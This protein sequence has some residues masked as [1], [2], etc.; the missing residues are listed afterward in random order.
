[1]RSAW[2]YSGPLTV[3]GAAIATCGGRLVLAAGA[4]PP[5]PLTHS[6]LPGIENRNLWG[7]GFGSSPMRMRRAR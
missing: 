4:T 2:R 1:M 7:R 5:M 6:S 3:S